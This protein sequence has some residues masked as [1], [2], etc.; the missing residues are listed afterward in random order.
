M[1]FDWFTFVAQLVNFGLLLLLLR[2]FL[3]KPVLNVMEQRQ[4]Q[5]TKAWED[6]RTAEAA[7]RA[8][9]AELGATRQALESERRNRLM[10]V[11]E[12]ANALRRRR[13][14]EAELEATEER[15]RQA[16]RL[17]A[18]RQA[19]V[20]GLVR[21]G[22]RVI[23]AELESALRELADSQLDE[24]AA[25]LF[26]RR[27][28][29]LP[30]EQAALLR[31]PSATPVITTALAPSAAVRELLTQA[32]QQVTGVGTEP[33]FRTDEGLLFGAALTVG[34]LRVEA[35]GQR[36]LAALSAAFE[37]ALTGPAAAGAPT[38]PADTAQARTERDA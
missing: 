18:E 36:R 27:L 32:V 15:A 38:E 33:E 20:A 35:S 12:E 11:E 22:G 14:E 10:Q 34:P 37:S 25:R 29:E 6:V 1:G 21:Q 7:A 4:R 31:D 23:A 13:L 8:E 24:Q 9:A 26:A 3:Y 30:E 16:A 2:L 28:T 17:E 5:L 19:L